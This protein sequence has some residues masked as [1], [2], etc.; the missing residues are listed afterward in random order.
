MEESGVGGLSILLP[1]NSIEC[2]VSL[3]GLCIIKCI[4]DGRYAQS[5]LINRRRASTLTKE[6]VVKAVDLAN[7]SKYE[8]LAAVR[9]LQV[10]RRLQHPCIITYNGS[11]QIRNHLSSVQAG[12]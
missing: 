3:F 9:E 2:D 4:G 11:L 7:L 6:R 8:R 1:H 12:I 5:Y 10:L